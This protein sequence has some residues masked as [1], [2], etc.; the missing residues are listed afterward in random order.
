MIVKTPP[1]GWNTWNTFGRSIN[2]Q[3]IKE[4]ADIL[5]DSG[6]KDLGY[7]YLVI[8]DCWSLKERDEQG[9]LQ[10]DPEKFPSGMKALAEYVHSKGLKFGMYSCCGTLTCAGYPSSYDYEFIDA[11]TFASWDVD[12]LKYDRC[13]KPSEA[14]TALLYR[15]MGY[16]L[17]HSGRDILYSACSWGVD[18]THKW[19][20][21][22]GAH[23]WRTTGDINDS[24]ESIKT[25]YEKNKEILPFS[26]PNC[27]GD[28]DMLIVGMNGKGNV[29]LKGCTKEEYRTHFT[30]WAMF[31][32]PLMIGCDI[33]S[34]DDDAKEILMNKDVIAINQDPLCAQ[35]IESRWSSWV[36]PLENGDF[37][38]MFVN[39]QDKDDK[40][41]HVNLAD[42]GIDLSCNKKIKAKNL[43][44]GEEFIVKNGIIYGETIEPHASKLFRCTIVNE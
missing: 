18:D 33:R 31:N 16:A 22:T 28:M 7:D 8:D 32:S 4:T 11:E 41:L 34:M 27:F 42:I 12:F 30:M 5:V 35:P 39:I 2:E 14:S 1:M 26:A 13:F 36:K 44:T 20:K 43:W 10:P 15:K 21:T 6:L 23:M 24:W 38:V 3:L 9:R 37:A 19:I 17:R 29:G 40:Y 25:L